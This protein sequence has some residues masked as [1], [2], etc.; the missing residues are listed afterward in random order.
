MDYEIC[1]SGGGEF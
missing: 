1:L